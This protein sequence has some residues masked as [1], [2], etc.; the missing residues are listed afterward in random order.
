LRVADAPWRCSQ[1][2]TVNEPNANSCRSCGRW[3]SLFDLEQS[4]V[5]QPPEVAEEVVVEQYRRD[6]PPPEEFEPPAE[7]MEQPEPVAEDLS[8]LPEETPKWPGPDD[9]L[10]RPV[11]GWPRVASWIVPIIFLLYVVISIVSN[12]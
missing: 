5:E 8:G 11:Q 9:P 4:A 12:R 1:C 6:A 3:P 10:D 2:G 7:P